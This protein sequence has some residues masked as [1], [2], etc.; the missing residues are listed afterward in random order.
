MIPRLRAFYQSNGHSQVPQDY[1]DQ[2][3][4]E[5]TKTLRYNYLWQ[6]RNY[7]DPSGRRK[8]LADNKM[9]QLAELDFSWETSRDWK[10]W[11]TM[12]KR[13]KEYKGEHGT[14]QIIPEIDSELYQWTKELRKN[15][16]HQAWNKTSTTTSASK[17]HLPR[18]ATRKLQ[19]L[20]EIGF[21]WGHTRRRKYL[22]WD[23]MLPKLRAFHEEHGHTRV[24]KEDDWELYQWS[25][26]IAQNYGFQLSNSTVST[27]KNST[28]RSYLSPTKIQELQSIGFDWDQRSTM[29]ERR[30][31]EL[32]NFRRANGH[33]YVTRLNNS[34][35]YNF[36]QF[37]RQEYRRYLAGNATTMT[38]YRIESL[39]KLDF[40]WGRPHE[41]LWEERRQELDQYYKL[42]GHSNV[43]QD[44]ADNYALGQWCMNQRT[45]YRQYQAGEGNT[46]TLKRIRKL[47]EVNFQWNINEM[48]WKEMFQ[49]LKDYDDEHGHTEIHISDQSN[50][51][52]RQWI[53]EQRY[54][55]RTGDTSRLTEE[56]IESL[57]S[58]DKFEWRR[59]HVSG[60]SKDDWSQLFVAIREKGI[61]PGAKAKE[62]IFDGMNRFA[63]DVKT[64]WSEQELVALWN[65]E[66]DDDENGEW[67]DDFEDYEDQD[68]TSFLRA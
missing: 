54:Y 7:S 22:R 41:K 43:P 47:E 32:Q 30:Y 65:E 29:W 53:N 9:E 55:Y 10:R 31:D 56:R 45:K 42:H 26:Q 58:I 21:D 64:E 12:L 46:M 15:Y 27:T 44:Y 25:K 19:A 14:T 6:V 13:L 61:A 16:R 62:H 18:L 63:Q 37:Q 3:L 39:K 68:A 40:D 51:D 11:P 67:H 36:V 1:K 33:C 8:R 52:L 66:E 59:E 2:E 48:K 35:L 4:F 20:N 50:A 57:E 49:R 5:W 28:T 17:N 24:K 38:P 34:Q 60:P 23:D